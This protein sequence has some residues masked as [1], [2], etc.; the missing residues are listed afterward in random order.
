[1]KFSGLTNIGYPPPGV[2]GWVNPKGRGNLNTT[3]RVGGRLEIAGV[4]VGQW[5]ANYARSAQ[6]RYAPQVTYFNRQCSENKIHLTES[7]FLIT[8]ISY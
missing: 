1:M 8:F 2:L 6:P 5:G 7:S 4:V 3:H